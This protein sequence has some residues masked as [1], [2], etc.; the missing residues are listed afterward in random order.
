QCEL[1]S[2]MLGL[3]SRPSRM[4]L[5]SVSVSIVVIFSIVPLPRVADSRRKSNDSINDPCRSRRFELGAVREVLLSKCF[6]IRLAFPRI[7]RLASECQAMRSV[8]SSGG[9]GVRG[10][11]LTHRDGLLVV[12]CQLFL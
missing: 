11:P 7:Y 8:T 9:V 6:A 1:R 3:A 4:S 10:W 12:S 5:C 2:A